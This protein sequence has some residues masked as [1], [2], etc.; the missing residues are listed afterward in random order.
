MNYSAYCINGANISI[1][2]QTEYIDSKTGNY[3]QLEGMQE[4]Y[5][6]NGVKFSET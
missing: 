2:I 3:S 4:G 5:M 1:E 6:V